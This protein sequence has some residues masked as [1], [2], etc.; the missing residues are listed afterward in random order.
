M[1]TTAVCSVSVV[2]KREPQALFTAPNI[3]ERGCVNAELDARVSE[4]AHKLVRPAGGAGCCAHLQYVGAVPVH[5]MPV[6]ASGRVQAAQRQGDEADGKPCQSHSPSDCSRRS[7]AGRIT[8]SQRPL[9]S[10]NSTSQFPST[11]GSIRVTS[12]WCS[13]R[14]PSRS[15]P[16]G[17][18]LPRLSLPLRTFSKSARQP[19]DTE[20][21]APASASGRSGRC[22]LLWLCFGR[23]AWTCRPSHHHHHHLP[24]QQ[25]RTRTLHTRRYKPAL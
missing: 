4:D 23:F 3:S 7:S 22:L 6:A 1:V 17:H 11:A 15:Q 25:Q 16:S 2:Y 12:G 14:I 5:R 13:G 10:F 19:S 21:R 9:A 8:T 20:R 24:P 18:L